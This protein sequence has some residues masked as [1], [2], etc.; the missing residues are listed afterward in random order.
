MPKPPVS[1]WVRHTA[2]WIR[3]VA[4]NGHALILGR[5][6][7]R[8]VTM[9]VVAVLLAGAT[10]AIA[11]DRVT[12]LPDDAALRV[13]DAVVT[14]TEL[15]ERIDALIALYGIQRPSEDSERAGEFRRHAAKAVAVSIVLDEVAREKGIVISDKAAR[16]RLAELIES[17]FGK[18]GRDKFV[19][20]LGQV[21]ASE[22]EVLAE[23]KRQRVSSRLLRDV[24]SKVADV[25]D[26]D[27]RAAFTEREDELVAPEQR[28]LRNIVVSTKAKAKR[29]LDRAKAGADFPALARKHSLDGSTSGDGGDLGFVTREQLE[30]SYAKAAFR[31]DKRAYFGP[32]RTEHGWNVGQVVGIRN[33]RQLGFA[34]VKDTL[35]ERLRSERE[36]KAWHDWLTK[37]LREADVEYAD[38]YRPR[39]PV[40][41]PE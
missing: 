20:L 19:D 18:G 35:R 16:D 12:G 7:R 23:I 3:R 1:T 30:K 5:R 2:A 26:K 17:G 34:E 6:R 21:G 32:V 40:A 38:M 14:E 36:L 28:R 27:V 10:S 39:D 41:P 9:V 29:L 24:G 15:E 11:Y 37:K 22:R 25:T 4:A 8:V 33:E 13:G 31:T